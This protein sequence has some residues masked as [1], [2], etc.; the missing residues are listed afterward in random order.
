MDGSSTSRIRKFGEF[1]KSFVE[2]LERQLFDIERAMDA[3][4]REPGEAGLVAE[5]IR[6][7]EA[8]FGLG[9]PLGM[10]QICRAATLFRSTLPTTPET[11]GPRLEKALRPF[12]APEAVEARPSP[13]APRRVF[14]LSAD[15]D[16]LIRALRPFGYEVLAWESPAAL[17]EALDVERPLAVLWGTSSVPPP[18]TR[19]VPLFVVSRDDGLEARIGAVRAGARG[20]FTPDDAEA[21]ADGLDRLGLEPRV[22]PP[23]VMIVDDDPVAAGLHAAILRG[24]GMSVSAVTDPAEA[25]DAL[26]PFD[27][28]LLLLDMDLGPFT[29]DELAAAARQHPAFVGI[30]IVFLSSESRPAFQFAARGAG[31]EDCLVKPV[32]PARLLSEVLLRAEQG[33]ALRT[34]LLLDG[35]TGALN[36]TAFPRRLRAELDLA[37]RR[38]RALAC[39]RLRFEGDAPPRRRH[40]ML[41]S[42]LRS[43]D[44]IGRS[45]ARAFLIAMPDCDAATA[46]RIL[47]SLRGAIPFEGTVAG[48]PEIGD[49]GRL[50]QA[51]ARGGPGVTPLAGDSVV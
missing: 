47:G 51:L 20:F 46:A 23:R 8:L 25:L 9:G 40:E 5:A 41:R 19:G 30:P 33:R 49:A 18:S 35:A 27:P 43:S 45:G 37:R 42:R 36:A 17:E 14:L 31:A 4:R 21:L 6:R 2:T 48:F 11:E 12:L 3:V 50:L 15:G 32:P 39:A 34:H 28:D 13:A 16:A 24:G 7:L 10:A 1:R 29:G 22:G 38:G 44:V 26:L